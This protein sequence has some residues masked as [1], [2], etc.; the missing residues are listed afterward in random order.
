[1]DIFTTIEFWSLVANFALGATTFVYANRTKGLTIMIDTIKKAI[2][3]YSQEEEVK[4]NKE[5]K[6]KVKKEIES[7]N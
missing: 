6:E 7:L 5:I 3:E 4:P 2:D 1:M